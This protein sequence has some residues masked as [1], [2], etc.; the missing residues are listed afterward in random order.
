MNK[1]KD[2][3]CETPSQRHKD[4]I[5]WVAQMQLK[6]KKFKNSFVERAFDKLAHLSLPIAAVTAAILVLFVITP[7]FKIDPTPIEMP[8][9]EISLM[10]LD[11][12]EWEDLEVVMDLEV[13]EDLEE[14]DQWPE[15]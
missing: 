7:R 15:G 4:H 8:V 5:L 14:V 1:K 12:D 9:T 10:T 3:I 13:L 11:P 2:F 6:E